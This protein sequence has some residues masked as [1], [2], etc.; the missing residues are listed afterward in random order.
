MNLTPEERALKVPQAKELSAQ[1]MSLT[2]IARQLE[3]ADATIKRWGI[4]ASVPSEGSR[5]SGVNLTPEERALKVPQARELRTQGMSERQIAEV[6]H[7]SRATVHRVLSQI[8]S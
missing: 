8:W 1:G 3:V 5:R 2:Q 6:L 4:E 7:V